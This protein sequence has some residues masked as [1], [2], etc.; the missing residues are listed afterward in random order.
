[1]TPSA[2]VA[3]AILS[4]LTI[5]IYNT[6]ILTSSNIFEPLAAVIGIQLTASIEN[7]VYFDKTLITKARTTE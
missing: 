6:Q 3:L 7:K 1:M 5:N 2:C 4:G